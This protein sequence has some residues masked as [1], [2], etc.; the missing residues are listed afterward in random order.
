MRF[1]LLM[2]PKGYEQAAAGTMPDPAHVEKMMVYNRALQD[3]G[4]LLSLDGLHPPRAPISLKKRQQRNTEWPQA[5]QIFEALV[6]LKRENLTRHATILVSPVRERLK[7]THSLLPQLERA[8]L[9][10]RCV[11]L[12]AS[13]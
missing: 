11:A 6:G 8:P 9:F 3:A 7:K 1:M 2:L 13:F 10:L 5:R 4:V 12:I